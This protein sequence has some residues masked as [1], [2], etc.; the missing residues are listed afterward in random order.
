MDL[1]VPQE[2]GAEPKS[3]IDRLDEDEGRIKGL[4]LD[5]ANLAAVAV[6]ST[7]KYLDALK[8]ASRLSWQKS[9]KSDPVKVVP[10]SVTILL[11]TPNRWVMSSMNF[12]ASF[13]VTVVTAQTSI[14][15]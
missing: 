6:L 11:G 3:L 14:H 4:L 15:L 10:R 7:V 9:Q 12:A 5:T 2:E 13:D 8:V 1:Y